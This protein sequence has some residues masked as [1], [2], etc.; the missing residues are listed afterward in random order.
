MFPLIRG[1]TYAALFISFVLVFLP[2]QV[3]A[4]AGV[5]M[6]VEVGPAQALGAVMVVL[7]L[8]LSIWCVLAFGIVGKGTPAP[9]DPPRRLVVRGPYRYVRNPMYIGAIVAL[10]G[11]TIFY[12]SLAL[13]GFTAL[14]ALTM[15]LF[16]L[17]YEEPTLTRLF[18]ADYTEYRRQ[19]RRWRPM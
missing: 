7:G 9:F 14:F 8:S 11:A 6:P 19:V 18:G 10:A 3:L 13:A 15:H 2:S 17:F 12:R 5:S 16:V 1:L 4:R